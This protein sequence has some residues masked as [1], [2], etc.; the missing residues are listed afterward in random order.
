[1]IFHSK[2]IEAP[3]L[4]TVFQGNVKILSFP[5]SAEF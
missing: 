1:M 2:P 3:S 5:A 4:D